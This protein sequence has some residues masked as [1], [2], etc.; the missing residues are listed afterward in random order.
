MLMSGDDAKS[1]CV[2]MIENGSSLEDVLR[3]LRKSE[4]SQGIS[5]YVIMAA[6]GFEHSE[7]KEKAIHSKVWSDYLSANL[8]IQE[9][10]DDSLDAFF[11]E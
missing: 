3:F 4:F 9:H 2:E 10:L 7:A 8:S 5:V 6:Y 1:K 11:D